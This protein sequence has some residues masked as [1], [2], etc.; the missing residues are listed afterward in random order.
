MKNLQKR[1]LGLTMAMAMAFTLLPANLMPTVLAA[2]YESDLADGDTSPPEETDETGP[3]T[4]ETDPSGDTETGE[5][6]AEAGDGDEVPSD[7]TETDETDPTDDDVPDDTDPSIETDLTPTYSSSSTD[8]SDKFPVTVE[9][10]TPQEIDDLV[11][12]GYTTIANAAALAAITNLNGRYV[13]TDNIALTGEWTPL[14]NGNNTANYFTGTFDGN[15]YTISG[16]AIS[17]SNQYSGLFGYVSGATIQNLGLEDVAIDVSFN[18]N[19]YA[20][21]LAGYA[22]AA[23]TATTAGTAPTSTLTIENCFVTGSVAAESASSNGSH[24]SYAGGLVGYL[25]AAVSGNGTTAI[26]SRG[27]ATALLAHCANWARVES[28]VASTTYTAY[29]GGLTGYASATTSGIYARHNAALTISGS[30]N[31]GAVKATTQSSSSTS[32]S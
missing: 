6:D 16:L 17:G 31:A 8:P 15:G 7:E 5:A 27:E 32:N 18:N 29:A 24:V 12:A 4:D 1:L 23:T 20:G 2:E 11:A 14:G 13:L 30:A 26:Q 21:G 28:A 19:I 10:Y 25:A 22:T 3:E 9:R